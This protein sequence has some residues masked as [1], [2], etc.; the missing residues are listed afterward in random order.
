MIIFN[1][2]QRS[3]HLS[4][5]VYFVLIATLKLYL[6]TYIKVVLTDCQGKFAKQLYS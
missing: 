5:K 4:F 3:A 6:K 1:W 2:H